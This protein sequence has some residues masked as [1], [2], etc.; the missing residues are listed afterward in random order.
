MKKSVFQRFIDHG[1]AYI[2]VRK[3]G[4]DIIRVSS[5]I[6]T[7]TVLFN[8]KMTGKCK[9]IYLIFV[10]NGIDKTKIGG[11]KLAQLIK[12]IESN[13][14]EEQIQGK[15]ELNNIL[16]NIGDDLKKGINYQI[17]EGNS[18]YEID[19]ATNNAQKMLK[20]TIFK[21]LKYIN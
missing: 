8:G 21:P 1:S 17:I 19:K 10:K 9:N 12:L 6:P 2:P 20:T 5:H 3:D 13:N 14:P 16:V 11:I 18:K 15:T 4:H 7:S